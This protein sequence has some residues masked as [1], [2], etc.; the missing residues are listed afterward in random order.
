ML[1]INFNKIISPKLNTEKIII[2]SK[3]EKK[4]IE[5]TIMLL[6]SN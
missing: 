3:S 5:N 4:K 6:R 1:K 2:F